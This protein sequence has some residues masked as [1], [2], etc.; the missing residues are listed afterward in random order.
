MNKVEIV[1]L[2]AGL[3]ILIAMLMPGIKKLRMFNLCGGIIMVVY[4]ILIKSLSVTILNSITSFINIYHLIKLS[5]I[6]PNYDLIEV[7]F[8]DLILINYIKT[9]KLN[10]EVFLN[11]DHKIYLFLNNSNIKGL[12][13]L[14]EEN[15][16]Y[17]ICFKKKNELR[18]KKEGEFII[19][20]KP[21]DIIIEGTAKNNFLNKKYYK[22]LGFT[23]N[24]S[25]NKKEIKFT[26]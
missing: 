21:K 2:V 4:G 26:Y 22:N 13:I 23:V 10:I 11:D 16:K 7:S 9:N 3:L 12:Y 8:N 5:I 14:K 25:E 20:K 15:G 18:N 1:G 6:K 24:I 17:I 19:S